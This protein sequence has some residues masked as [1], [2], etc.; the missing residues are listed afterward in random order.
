MEP[1]ILYEDEDVLVI[2]KPSG[3]TVNRAQ[4]TRHE[5]TVQDWTEQLLKIRATPHEIRNRFWTSQNDDNNGE[6]HSGEER[7]ATTPESRNSDF[8]FARRAGIVHRLDKETS[9]ILLI[10]KTPQA[11]E[12]LQGQFKERIVAKKY[13]ALVH[14]V[15]KPPEGEIRVPV[16][17]LPW[18]R[19]RFGI[20]AGGREAVTR[21]RRLSVFSFRLS[22]IGQS[23]VGL[24]V[25]PKNRQQTNWKP[26]TD[27]GEPITEYYSL[28]ELYPQTG[29]THQIR[30]HLKYLGHPIVA[31]MLYGGR[32]QAR[33][34]RKWCP[35]LFLHASAITFQHPKTGE[36]INLKSELPGDLQTVL[37]KISN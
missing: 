1:K 31:D 19:M 21:Y 29:R 7:K 10:A 27:N 22:D 28:L 35:R 20:V 26:K 2:D 34:D 36:N 25:K 16:G 18:N 30:V 11:F 23:V 17:R 5:E 32:K 24:S 3:M 12:N 9:G 37:N 14:G 8:E 6:R 15:V 4:T 13:I 33:A